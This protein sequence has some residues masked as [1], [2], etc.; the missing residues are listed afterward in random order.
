MK[1][2]ARKL[3]Y[4]L[5]IVSM[6][7]N[8]VPP[9]RSSAMPAVVTAPR[10]QPPDP[11]AQVN[12]LTQDPQ[13]QALDQVLGGMPLPDG[14]DAASLGIQP[15][16]PGM[17]L[18]GAAQALPQDQVADWNIYPTSPMLPRVNGLMP[19]LPWQDFD[20]S[21]PQGITVSTN[22][23]GNLPE[24]RIGAKGSDAES[25]I[26][27]P[28]SA[29][30]PK[31]MARQGRWDPKNSTSEYRTYLPLLFSQASTGNKIIVAAN[32]GD[33]SLQEVAISFHPNG[34]PGDIVASAFESPNLLT[35][36][37][38]VV[39]S[40]KVTI[41][42]NW[43]NGVLVT[44]LDPMAQPKREPG[45]AKP[46]PPQS[47]YWATVNIQLTPEQIGNHSLGIARLSTDGVKWEILPTQ[48]NASKG[49]ATAEVDR[50]GTFAL[51]ENVAL[52]ADEKKVSAIVV[53]AE[54][55]DEILV[56]DLASD[57]ARYERDGSNDFWWNVPCG[58]GGC[59]AG[60]AWWTWN[61]SSYEH[62]P[63]D[64]PWNWADWKPTLPLAGYYYV[65]AF[66]PSG[67]ATTSGARYQ[68]HHN[69]QRDDV[70]ISQLAVNGSWRR[71]ESF[72]FAADGSEYVRLTD[73]VPEQNEL[74]SQV[75]Y[76]AVRFIYA[77]QEP[78]APIDNQKPVIHN[79]DRFMSNGQSNFRAK[80][81]DNVAVASVVLIFNG[82]NVEMTPIGGDIY[83]ATVPVPL[84]QI[85]N[86]QVV[87]IDTTGNM[88][89]FPPGTKLDIRGYVS[90][91]LGSSNLACH[92]GACNPGSQ[93]G[94]VD[95]INTDPSNGNFSY[96]HVDLVVLGIGDTDI[97]IRRGYN[98]MPN[99][100]QG[101]IRYSLDG[102]T[103]KAEPYKVHPE[104]FGLNS[105]LLLSIL[106]MDNALL[107][108]AQVRYPDGRTADFKR[109]GNAFTPVDTRIY[110]TLTLNGDEYTLTTQDLKQYI[111]SQS[112][113]RL[114]R[115]VD[116]NG[117]FIRYIY[118]G[119]RLTRIENSAGRWVTL[120]YTG[121]GLV[122]D[123]HAPEGIHLHYAY[124]DDH[125]TAFTDANGEIWKYVYDGEGR[126][127]AIITPEG[128]PSLQVKYDSVGR[129]IE[130]IEGATQ[131]TTLT[132]DLPARTTTV[133]NVYGQQT[134]HVYDEK[135]RAI[136]SRNAAGSEY[137]GYNDRDERIDYKDRNGNEWH[138]SYNDRGRRITEDGPLSSH[139]EW[140]Y[141]DLNLV[142]S[143]IEKIDATRNRVMTFTYDAKGNLIELCNP[144]DCSSITYDG[145]GL[146]TLV[147]DFAGNP[148]TNTYDTEGDLRASTNGEGETTE[149][150]HNALGQLTDMW[151]P[152]DFHYTYAYDKIGHITDVNGPYGYHLGYTYDPN[153]NLDTSTDP[154]GGITRYAH[155]ASENIITVTSPMI[156]VTATYTYGLMNELKSFTD[157]E[158]RLWEYEYDDNLR[159]TDLYGPEDTHTQMAYDA[160]GNVTDVTDTLGR[161]THTVYDALYRPT[162]VTLNYKL[163]QP[164]NADTNVTTAYEYNL[165]GDVLKVTDAED[166][167]TV[168]E[169]D[170]L[171]RMTFQRD[172]EGQETKYEYDEMSNVEKATNP[173]GFSTNYAYD[174]AN[175]LASITDADS[176]ITTFRYD[177][178][179]NLSDQIDA[180]GVITHYE[181]NALDRPVA[182]IRNYLPGTP[183]DWRTNVTTGYEYDLAGNLRF[184][185]DPRGYRAE[186]RYD[187]AM[188]LI[189]NFD[190]EGGETLFTYDRVDNLLTV[191]DDNKHKT[192]YAYD[193][194][195]RR[196]SITNPEGHVVTFTYNKLGQLTDLVD[197]NG[198]PT[199]YD[200]DALGRV[201]KMVDALD[202]EWQYRYNRVGSLLEEIDAN[203]HP[204]TYTY[205]KVYRLLDVTDAEGNITA[206]EWD[207]NGNL[208]VRTDGNQHSTA[209][210]YDELDRLITLTN[211]ETETTRYEYDA[212][213]N[214]THLIE[215]DD[216]VTLYGYDELYRLITVT[217]DY[218]PGEPADND[219]NVV[220]NYIYDASGNLHLF[221]NAN[222]KTTTFE[223]DGMGR[224]TQEVDALGN[225]W[226][227]TYDGVGNLLTRRDANRQLTAYSYFDDDQL[228]RVA[229]QNGQSVEYTYDRN[230]NRL[231]MQDSLGTTAW[232]YDE[233]NRLTSVTD[234]FNR[235]LNYQLDPVGNG[236][237]L[238]YP[239]GLWV[240]YTYLDNNWLETMTDPAGNV[241]AYTRDHVGNILVADYPNDIL[242]TI[243][244]DKADRTLTLVN[245]QM[246]GAQKTN[247]AFRYTYNEVGHVTQVVNTYGWRNPPV[248]TEDYTYDGLHR[249]SGM[250][251][252]EGVVMS[253]AYDKVG[254]RIGWTTNDDLTTQTPRDGFV[255]AYTY[256]AINQLT[257]A[258]IDSEHDVSDIVMDFRY[259]ANG[260]RVNKEW[261]GPQGP[262]TQGVVYTYD[263]ENRLISALD[264]QH[265][266][267]KRVDRALTTL[268]YDGG[269]RRLVQTYDP[270]IAPS[271]EKRIEYTFDGLDPVAEY[272]MLNGQ[273]D[274]YYR[275][276][277]GRIVTMH[278]F[279][280]GT[281]GQMY[282]YSYNFKGDVVGLSK[283]SGQST[284]NYRYDPYGGVIP[285]NGNFT[286]PHNHY[287]LTGKEYDENTGLVYFGARHYNPQSV[288]WMTQD[289]YRGIQKMPASMHRYAYVHGNPTSLI[290]PYGHAVQ[291]GVLIVVGGVMIISLPIIDALT[292]PQQADNFIQRNKETIAK[293]AQDENIDPNILA[294][295]LHGEVLRNRLV[296]QLANKVGLSKTLGPAQVNIDD[297]TKDFGDSVCSGIS[298]K[299]F[300]ESDEGSIKASALVFK[301][302]LTSATKPG[303]S[304]E[305]SLKFSI[306]A[307]QGARN[308]FVQA[309]QKY[310]TENNLLT[311]Y[312]GDMNR[313][314]SENQEIL[315]YSNI[316]KNLPSKTKT[317]IEEVLNYK[318]QPLP[319]TPTPPITI[320][321]T[322]SVS[323]PPYIAN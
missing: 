314:L 60:H 266:G 95:P 201:V 150:D 239:D 183:A 7:V 269:G 196:I 157:A 87:A 276:A 303:R 148:T 123:I 273:R 252:S 142:T 76:D 262:K 12:A 122:S 254:N 174:N 24:Y 267:G 268:A 261:G 135:F 84:A 190:F 57:F 156:Y 124:T 61:R 187:A 145:R 73:V 2:A 231:T 194:L 126:L 29:F 171:S 186:Y 285:D 255:A 298:V 151:T 175:R 246:V 146:P 308:E 109:N 18:P 244:Y 253:Y 319:P 215:A 296:N 282:W 102:D 184:V 38:F 115:E 257:Q 15:S 113:G 53:Q 225:T 168:F 5:V 212:L 221:V 117:N 271:G 22:D 19:S 291:V 52:W 278:H 294:G 30:L 119:D 11:A 289:S 132:Y 23:Q 274:N 10:V 264:Y 16:A 137:Y 310:I 138:Y 229:Y 224:L 195:D 208:I 32:G 26:N 34:L 204:T 27:A 13:S 214:Q 130:Q 193:D 129:A 88:A 110:D 259:D 133:T 301:Q 182:E 170:L 78:P 251:N 131:R 74:G 161:V 25:L 8:L 258:N 235:T 54:I 49:V 162:S 152:L 153:G 1:S 68:V 143:F 17:A 112:S 127:S 300:L 299:E 275:G 249:L 144:Y 277:G 39:Y 293:V 220:T 35:P 191:T 154:N 265:Q 281:Q 165:V 48:V 120:E 70:V 65:D 222:E 108:G 176:K 241:T 50:L 185:T 33:L 223:H 247:S 96:S 75:G 288:Q 179:G 85:S 66:I 238:Q 21:L 90:R 31:Q 79:V 44:A 80:V 284:H 213:G 104:F 307:Y 40:S 287:T 37:N 173:R 114:L 205:D 232:V 134:V 311:Q 230:N 101:V 59:W 250:T 97:V 116:R 198:N 227:Y 318:L 217:E 295:I 272:S 64:I 248:V 67:G 89:V 286:D 99:E 83:E 290:D 45:A 263:P 140:Q 280:S 128:H 28:D 304:S 219:T 177:D 36:D 141:N 292:A 315:Q 283:Q 245:Q 9:A 118:S 58:P 199:H 188:R 302:K 41:Q 125:L 47:R 111:V 233:L 82:Q 103:V 149:F 106:T 160:V 136:E 46:L 320:P 163:G 107:Q 147:T 172:A 105:S 312:N 180:Q 69:G 178:D 202:G 209:Y 14:V 189:A 91:N 211:P 305:D 306:G 243:T 234:P 86:W 155:D 236:T 3:L 321:A 92:T 279:P 63:L 167:P 55:G 4:V 139:R 98:S 237:A 181:Y 309:Q 210:E 158:G 100:F 317:R 71:L 169:Y 192:T 240:K 6:L 20:T 197:A 260:N 322:N 256:N 159:L 166:N 313:A 206:F 121:D 216:T 203:G 207:K 51:I 62:G 43:M 200:L 94:A 270:K 323:T 297:F 218:R 42:A 164:E 242:T 81:T 228:R 72:Y 316:E 56:D 77:G 226:D 93:L